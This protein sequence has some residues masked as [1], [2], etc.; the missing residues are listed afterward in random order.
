MTPYLDSAPVPHHIA[1]RRMDVGPMQPVRNPA[2][3]QVVRWVH[4]AEGPQIVQALASATAAQPEWASVS[5]EHRAH[6][7]R[8]FAQRVEAERE[9]VAAMI[10]AE[11]GKTYA[12]ALEEVQRGLACVDYAC[13]A[14]ALLAGEHHAQ[15]GA[16]VDHWTQP[17]ALGVVLGVAPFNEPFAVPLWMAPLALACGN[18]FV[19]KPSPQTPSVSVWMAEALLS[20]G[21]PPGLFQVLHGGAEV[22]NGLLHHPD[23]AA[24][25]VV[26]STEVA[27]ALYAKASELGKRVQALGGAKNHLVVMPDADLDAVCDALLGAAYGAAGARSMGVSVVVPVGKAGDML[28][29]RLAERVRALR[30]GDGMHEDVDLGPVISAEAKERIEALIRSGELD[31][32]HL[33]VDGRR[34]AVSGPPSGFFVGATLFDHVQPWMRI[35]QEEILGPVLVGLRVRTVEAALDLIHSHP[36]AHAVSLFTRD[37]GVAHQFKQSVQAGMV[38]VNVST[39][40]PMAWVGVGGWKA[41]LFGGLHAGGPDGLRFYTRRKAVLQRWGLVQARPHSL[42]T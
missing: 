22:V 26:G 8:R 42:A 13:G 1:G 32:A 21:L 2:T 4:V 20:A 39:P 37:G 14:P 25:S 38:G 11:Q 10:T 19:L 34:R 3:G 30:L 36:A 9:R 40:S 35:Y 28:M 24:L 29:P 7:L 12:E 15:A 17:E 31:G 18:A 27:R 33:V 41:S 23:V 5:A 16:G 6:V